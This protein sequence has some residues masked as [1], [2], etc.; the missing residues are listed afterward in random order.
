VD[1]LSR[2]VEKE[3]FDIKEAVLLLIGALEHVRFEKFRCHLFRDE[4]VA[5]LGGV[6]E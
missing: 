3:G 4:A 1:T 5:I 6:A 2:L